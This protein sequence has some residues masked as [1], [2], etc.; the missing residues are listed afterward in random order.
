MF[1]FILIYYEF[2]FYINLSANCAIVVISHE[3]YMIYS[4]TRDA[5]HASLTRRTCRYN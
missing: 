3:S 2:I 1:F 5:N 4:K